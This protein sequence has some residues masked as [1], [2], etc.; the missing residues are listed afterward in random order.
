M[1]KIVFI[2]SSILSP[3]SCGIFGAYYG[4]L[5]QTGFD[6]FVIYASCIATIV[7]CIMWLVSGFMLLV[8]DTDVNFSSDYGRK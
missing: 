7:L 2:I 4:K 6:R 1:K 5:E 8:G 3:I